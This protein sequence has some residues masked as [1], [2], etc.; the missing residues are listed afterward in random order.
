MLTDGH[1][2]EHYKIIKKL[3]EGG[4]GAV[5]LAEDQKLGR[6]VA[7]KILLQ[8]YFD[9]AERAERFEREAR[10]AAKINNQYVMS[11]Y[12][13]GESKDE[14]TDQVI[15]YIEM[16]YIE[17]ESLG[18]YMSRYSDDL[19][20]VVR[21]AEKIAAGL[22]AAHKL[23]IVHRDIKSDNIL[24]DN[25]GNPKILDFGL[26]KP[27][28]GFVSDGQHDQTD[29]ISRELTKAGKILGTVSFMSPEQARG[30]ALD[31]RSDIFSFGILLYQMAT[32]IMPFAGST[33]VSTLAKILESK[34]EPPSAKNAN[35]PTE[36]ER[37]IDKCLQKDAND[38]YQ[39]TRDL[40]VDLRSHRRQHDSGVTD[41]VSGVTSALGGQQSKTYVFSLKKPAIIIAAIAVIVI[42]AI[43]GKFFS[44]SGGQGNALQASESGLAIIGFENKTGDDEYTWLETGLPEIML[45]DL[46]QGQVLKL[47]SRERILD[48]FDDRDRASHS[49]QEFVRAAQ[50]LGAAHV[51]SGSFYKVGS[52][53]RIDARMEEAA[54][55]KIVFAE[56]VVGSDPFV[57]VDSLTNKIAG[58]LDVSEQLANNSEV[59]RFTSSSQEA[60]KLYLAGLQLFLNGFNDEAREK[61]N[62]A[63]AIDSSFALAYMREGMSYSLQGQ[64]TAGAKYLKLAKDREAN[65]PPRERALLAVYADIWLNREFDNA[66]SKMDLFVNTYPDDKEGRAIY[67]V[68]LAQIGNNREGGIAQ[69]DT[70]VQLD[71]TFQLAY[72]FYTEIYS[73][74]GMIDSAI[75]FARRHLELHPESPDPYGNLAALYLREGRVDEAVDIRRESIRRFP[76]Q[77]QPCLRISDLFVTQK[78]FDSARVYLEMFKDRIGDDAFQLRAYNYRLSNLA[79][80]EGHLR[81]GLK[82]RHRALDAALRTADSAAI[83]NSYSNL[84]SYFFRYE[85]IDSATYYYEKAHEWASDIFGMSYPFRIIKTDPSRAEEAIE[86]FNKG[87]DE[88]QSR[89]PSELWPQT[90]LIKGVFMALVSGDTVEIVTALEKAT[91]T[92]MTISN[93]ESDLRSLVEIY[94][95]LGEYE[96]ARQTLDRLRKEATVLTSA[97]SYLIDRYHEGRILEGEGRTREA[98]EA[99]SEFLL[100][101]GNADIQLKQISDAKTRLKR[102]TS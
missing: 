86:L 64:Q 47:I 91:N 13:I 81:D 15:H 51:L 76:E 53:I 12:S 72:Q 63:I 56:K 77:A 60:Y 37:I 82:Y 44:G 101:W 5:Y 61:F 73:G 62:A 67:G 79:N 11:I 9:N 48:T 4:M 57:L 20:Q 27:A 50:K 96:K 22:A 24:V 55:G 46:A 54:T 84:G 71:P 68:L 38:R 3:G 34:H 29:T 75:Y 92:E 80:W 10:T 41:T 7:L 69:L 23:G 33:Q 21:L 52:Q 95:A 25:E 94:V 1:Q 43:A 6:K 87:F 19:K 40:V 16:E 2:F 35:V 14:T 102:L 100:Y 99:Y 88:F 83:E 28:E 70:A 74:A 97:W 30:E 31:T 26:A 98:A 59:T 58:S 93:S 8:E 89:V 45:T 39:D 65:L 36:L 66:M 17:G 32:G 78:T 42:I 49:H 85:I 18:D 90:E